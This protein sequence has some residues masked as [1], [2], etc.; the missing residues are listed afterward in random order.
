MNNTLIH[1]V[2]V[3]RG[4]HLESTHSVHIA[5]VNQYGKILYQYGD[6]TRLTFARS[7]M[8]PFQ[9]IPLVATGAA[10]NYHFSLKDLSVSCASHSGESFHRKQVLSILDRIGLPESALQCG[11]H[12]PRDI[13][14][15]KA[16]IRE[17][18]ELSPVFSNCSGKHSGMVATAVHMGEDPS[19][20]YRVE[21]PV[22]K[23][24]IDAIENVC[25][26]PRYQ[27]KLGVDGCGVPVHQIPLANLGTGFARLTQ[28]MHGTHAFADELTQIRKAMVSHPEMVGG[29]NRFDTDLMRVYGD[30]IVAKA[31]A[32]GVQAIGIKDKGWG[33]AFKVEDG[34][35][36]AN[37]A[38]VMEVLRQLGI[39]ESNHFSQLNK[40]VNPIMK[41]KREEKIGYIETNFELQVGT[42]NNFAIK[43]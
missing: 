13:E 29:T 33:I 31:G 1:N 21:H 24:I 2:T 8:K 10:E 20:Y 37:S 39:G 11:T 14:S 27:M 36:R 40:Y 9:A 15:Y 4:G 25:D 12:I 19:D 26:F 17:G 18:K 16:L 30:R 23:R 28:A 35:G 6:P 32:E 7:S 22:Q 3:Y 38:V 43:E 42:A 34:N 5:V 41:N